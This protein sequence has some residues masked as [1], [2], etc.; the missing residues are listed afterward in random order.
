MGSVALE[1]FGSG[2]SFSMEL[3]WENAS[4]TSDFPAQSVDLNNLEFYDE[5]SIVVG[6]A[7]GNHR[8]IFHVRNTPNIFYVSRTS[9]IS[10]GTETVSRRTT[11]NNDSIHF[12]QANLA[13]VKSSITTS[14]TTAE[15]IPLEIFGIKWGVSA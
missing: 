4:P 9:V 5:L 7:G 13:Q 3:V 6:N 10:G 1:G 15:L 12:E 8:L 14:S 2:G 11:L